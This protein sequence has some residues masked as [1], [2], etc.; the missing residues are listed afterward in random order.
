MT[1]VLCTVCGSLVIVPRGTNYLPREIVGV[2]GDNKIAI[3]QKTLQ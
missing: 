2:E 3:F 1:G